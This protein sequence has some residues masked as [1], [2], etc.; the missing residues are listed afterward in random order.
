MPLT[1]DG[2]RTYTYTLI[3]VAP[4]EA[5]YKDAV[6]ID[7][8]D[9]PLTWDQIPDDAQAWAREHGYTD[10]Q[11]MYVLPGVLNPG[12][13]LTSSSRMVSIKRCPAEPGPAGYP[14][15][16]D[17]R[18]TVD[19]T[20]LWG[21]LPE[22][23]SFGDRVFGADLVELLAQV[24]KGSA[25]RLAAGV[26]SLLNRRDQ[27]VRVWA[28][29]D[30]DE[31]LIDITAWSSGGCWSGREWWLKATLA[32]Q[33]DPYGEVR[34]MADGDITL[35]VRGERGGTSVF[36]DSAEGP[37]GTVAARWYLAWEGRRAVR[38]R[39]GATQPE[40]RHDEPLS[41][42]WFLLNIETIAEYPEGCEHEYD[43]P[44]ASGL[45]ELL[46][47][48]LGIASDRI[49]AAL[50]KL[51]ETEGPQIV[52]D[53]RPLEGCEGG[54]WVIVSGETADKIRKAAYPARKTW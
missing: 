5:V 53:R 28:T 46:E 22:S 32:A 11:V 1:D 8:P 18:Q 7:E 31:Q 33:F 15:L 26:N 17:D 52:L 49:L 12:G 27:N 51:I 4:G 41:L 19:L 47:V 50:R 3:L 2:V 35:A 21:R 42:Q 24:G 36:V 13:P 45:A 48:D 38:A 34:L 9:C 14:E 43:Y 29:S 30:P 39:F 20:P 37:L 54:H 44:L 16:H 40:L 6:P 23:R 25:K 10:G